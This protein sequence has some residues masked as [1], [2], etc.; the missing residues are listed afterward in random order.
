MS[1]ES[2]D[3]WV[4]LFCSPEV[5]RGDRKSRYRGTYGTIVK[6]CVYMCVCG[7]YVWVCVCM[8]VRVYVWIRA[9]VFLCSRR[10]T[11]DKMYIFEEIN[12]LQVKTYR[13]CL[14]RNGENILL[15]VTLARMY[16]YVWYGCSHYSV[17]RHFIYPPIQTSK[18]AVLSHITPSHAPPLLPSRTVFQVAIFLEK[19][20]RERE[21]LKYC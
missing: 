9:C 20:P 14:Y 7:V 13:F 3:A 6:L 21:K 10:K 4:V 1:S 12:T 15:L 17:L 19:Y 11:S 18:W 16:K 8:C 5:L 2:F